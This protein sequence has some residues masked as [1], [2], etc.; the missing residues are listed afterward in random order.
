M[1]DILEWKSRP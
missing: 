1:S